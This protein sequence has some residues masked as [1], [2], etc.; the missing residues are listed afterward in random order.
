MNKKTIV[1]IVVAVVVA[2]AIG[3]YM[4]SQSKHAAPSPATLESVGTGATAIASSAAQGVV[5]SFGNAVNPLQNQP[6]INPLNVTNPF[7]Q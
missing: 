1:L 4:Y 3:G 7:N 2:G 5:P 6:N